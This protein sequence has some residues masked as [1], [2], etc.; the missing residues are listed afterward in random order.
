MAQINTR[1]GYLMDMLGISGKELALAIGTDTTAVSKWRSG[2]RKLKYRSKYSKRIAAYFLSEPYTFQKQ[3]I[4]SLLSNDGMTK[5]NKTDDEIIEMLSVW[6]T[7]DSLEI[8]ERGALSDRQKSETPVEVYSGYAGWKQAVKIFWETVQFLPPGQKIYIGDFGDVQWDILGAESVREMVNSIKRVIEAGHKVVIIDKMTD[9]Y[10]PYIVILRWLPIYLKKEVEVLYFQKDLKEFYKK[11]IYA[12]ENYIA[13][14][15]MSLEEGNCENLTMLHRDSI[16]VNFYL[17]MVE[18]I[19]TKS[20]RLIY[21]SKLTDVMKMV[22][23]MEENF[24]PNQLT[25]MINHLPTFRNMP[26]HLLE[27]ILVANEVSGEKMAICLKA[28]RKRKE[29]RD[30]F[31]Y[32]QIYDLDAIEK[33]LQQEYFIDYDLSQVIGKEAKIANA[34]FREQLEYISKFKASEIYTLVMTSFKDLNLNIDNTEIVVQDDSIVIAWNSEYYDRRMYCKE[35]T[36][37]GGYFNYL[38]EIW[39]QIPLIA[40]NDEWTK[41]QLRRMLDKG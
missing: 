36:V 32:R 10:K 3:R 5:E 30:K 7:V 25:Y 20:K 34:F 23:L 22:N 24:K 35:L 6:M 8:L 17:K 1:I 9:Q 27:R 29:L 21:T 40:K 18:S 38:K 37:V 14:V 13:M 39:N 31:N 4:I 28:N 26:L 2:Q 16:S 33:A 15:G 11:S 41:K 12:V 19:A